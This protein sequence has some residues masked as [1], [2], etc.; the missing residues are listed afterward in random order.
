MPSL[1]KLKAQAAR[2]LGIT[3]LN[4]AV[5]YL[6]TRDINLQS[7]AESGA[8]GNARLREAFLHLFPVLQPT[9]FCD[10]GAHDGSMSLAVREHAPQ[11]EVHAFEANPRIHARHAP[12][13]VA[14]GVHW[15][16]LAVSDHGGSVSLFA[17]RTLSRA[18][19]DGRIVDAHIVE[20]EDT[21]KTSLLRRNEAATY[22]THEV[23]ATTL[24]EFF[25][26]RARAV[27]E[28]KFFLWIDVEGA[29]D[30]VLAGAASVLEE[31]LAIFVE[32]ENEEFWTNQKRCDEIT[33]LLYSRNFL[34]VARD[35]EYDD[36]QFNM[37]FVNARVAFA[38]Q[39]HFFDAAS[40]LRAVL[41]PRAQPL[42]MTFEPAAGPSAGTPAAPAR[43]LPD[44]P[45][46]RLATV[47][48]WL[49]TEIP[50]LVPTFNNP[51]Y[52]AN[53]LQ[54]LRRLGFKSI[55]VVD[56]ASTTEAMHRW[57]D[58][59]ESVA[60]VIRSPANNGPRHTL[61]TPTE[62]A[63]LPQ[64]F[65][66]TDPDLQL[67]AA[68]PENFLAELAVLIDKY[69]VGKAGF[70]LDISDPATMRDQAFRIGDRDWKI[71]QWEAQF[72]T[73]KLEDLGG[74]DPVYDAP[75]DTTFA[76]YDKA[77][78]R[79]DDYLKAVRVAGRF[80]ARH[81][82]WYRK[83]EVPED[84]ASLY[85][86]TQKFSYY[87]GGPPAAAD[88]QHACRVCAAAPLQLRESHSSNGETFDLFACESCGSWSFFPA[89]AIDYTRHTENPLTI[90]CYVENGAAI[91]WMAVNVMSAIGQRPRGR[92]LD[93]GC[94]F[95]FAADVARRLAGWTVV[96][97]E[98]STWGKIGR[99]TLG[100]DIVTEFVDASHPLAKEKFDIFHASEV[101]EHFADPSQFLSLVGAFL[102]SRGILV[103]TTPNA[104][105]LDSDLSTSMRL[106]LLSIGAHVVLF[107]KSGLE[108]V[109]KQ[110]GFANVLVEE[111]GS[112]LVAYA[113]N[114]ALDL[115]P[116]EPAR[117]GRDYA[118]AIVDAGCGD[119]CL[120]AGMRYRLFRH[121]VELGDYAG[122]AELL[123]SLE[124][125][126]RSPAERVATLAEFAARD[127]IYA[128]G[129][130]FY[131]G[132]LYLNHIKD[133]R[134]ARELF[135]CSKGYCRQLGSLAPGDFVF[136][137]ELAWRA[138][139]HEGLSAAFAGDVG[140]ARAAF[141][142]IVEA[143]STA[144]GDV[145]ADLVQRAEAELS[146]T[147]AV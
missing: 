65:C 28:R 90:K 139:F 74:I 104:R 53:M 94:G 64:R 93:F 40:P 52:A 36:K 121:R 134:R 61:L 112:S 133:Y 17:P 110:A 91:D 119:D 115:T 75:I 4:T 18:Y 127:R 44:A 138:L 80:T 16:N 124:R 130:A 47:G 46:R 145:P 59:A 3:R 117:I 141:R 81:L 9:V 57:L 12:A 79:P 101:I 96:G 32:V 147:A 41:A 146:G 2:R 66:L 82:P 122:A 131:A 86:S 111:R 15:H 51:T 24:D 137:H 11:C 45:R 38:L 102:A 107:S 7:S 14:R 109:L 92:L 37:L 23:A 43:L 129:A 22:D 142:E 63:L 1:A 19:V 42:P 71:W 56:N 84:E 108:R 87:H 6:L 62:L 128:G 116:V 113:S 136:E 29:A 99:D 8:G 50:V 132:I 58:I 126:I 5:Q 144:T 88:G 120:L 49:Q 10:I 55:V 103:L 135:R 33:S 26:D 106:A 105:A 27:L 95:G 20:G 114:D 140:G 100:L 31:T 60:T 70:A 48:G 68:L 72:W 98:P 13:L 76:L 83:S 34:P 25:R 73:S 39:R 85:R 30:K 78:F 21:G 118:A 123:A 97:V 54:Q 69:R 125:D 143:G 35:R 89:P 67:N 77:H